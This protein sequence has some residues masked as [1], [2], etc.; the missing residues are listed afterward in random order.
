MERAAQPVACEVEGLRGFRWWRVGLGGWLLSPWREAKPWDTGPNRAR[1]L[2]TRRL[3]GWNDASPH[4]RGIP[5]GRC[6]CG[7]YG[8]HSYPVSHQGP[9]RF[10]W[11]LDTDFSGSGGL[12]LGVAEA[13]GRVLVGTQGWRAEFA[14]ACALYISTWSF[15]S[16]ELD[17]VQMRYDMPVYRDFDALREEWGPDESVSELLAA[18]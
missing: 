12:V 4:P 2:A 1:C 13:S 8:L 9:V 11:E 3:F 15:P 5:D 10:V 18:G 14:R 7:F 17:A 6:Q 16:P